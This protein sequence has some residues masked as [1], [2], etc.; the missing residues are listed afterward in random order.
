MVAKPT[1]NVANVAM[2]AAVLS[3]GKNLVEITTA[4]LPKC[5]SHTILSLSPVRKPKLLSKFF[6]DVA[7][8]NCIFFKLVYR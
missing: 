4:K 6:V 2:K 5:R 8:I 1:A 3:A 7:L